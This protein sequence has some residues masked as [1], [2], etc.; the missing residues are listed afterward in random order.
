MRFRII[1]MAALALAA[2][3][4]RPAQAQVLDAGWQVFHF[5]AAPAVVESFT[6][7]STGPFR[8]RL[9]DCCVIGDRF[10]LHTGFPIVYDYASS[11]PNP[12]WN[13]IGSGCFDGDACWADGRLSMLELNFIDPGSWDLGTWGFDIELLENA[14]GTVSG[15]GFYRVDSV[16]DPGIVPEPS[17]YVLV[18]SGL[19]GLAGV[20]RRRRRQ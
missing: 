9:V 1:G 16:R 14:A 7:S 4:A 17:T 15:S 10:R 13:G 5:G 2:V 20:A 18:A 6:V 19:V 3:T 11:T 8:V 12:I